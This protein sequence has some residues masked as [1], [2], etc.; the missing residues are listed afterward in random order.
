MG[1][2]PDRNTEAVWAFIRALLEEGWGWSLQWEWLGREGSKERQRVRTALR[3]WPGKGGLEKDVSGGGEVGGPRRVVCA[4]GQDCSERGQDTGGSY[5]NRIFRQMREGGTQCDD[6]GVGGRHWPLM[7]ARML[8]GNG[9]RWD[10]FG[11][12]MRRSWGQSHL[13]ASCFLMKPGPEDGEVRAPQGCSP[14]E[15]SF[16]G[17]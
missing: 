7:G 10:R 9:R 3:C 15:R 2:R 11:L 14:R 6:V 13:M 16:C 8:L 12:Y 17:H 1:V 4:G 5:G